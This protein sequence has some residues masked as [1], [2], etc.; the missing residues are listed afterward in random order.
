MSTYR[1]SVNREFRIKE[2]QII[3]VL[4]Y[5]KNSHSLILL[6]TA[7]CIAG[8]ALRLAEY[9]LNTERASDIFGVPLG[10]GVTSAGLLAMG[11]MWRAPW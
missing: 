3:E 8:G 6:L 7:S 10:R 11:M 2:E 1:R 5:D 4:L 9:C